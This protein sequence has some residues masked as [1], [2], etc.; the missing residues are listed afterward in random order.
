MHLV[1][2]KDL[3]ILRR[4]ITDRIAAVLSG[5]K[6]LLGHQ[7]PLELPAYLRMMVHLLARWVT[8][9][10]YKRI[11]KACF[12]YFQEALFEQDFD[13]NVLITGSYLVA[14]SE[15]TADFL[16]ESTWD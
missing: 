3:R 10:H 6:G 16:Q 8:K 7:R 9:H 12:S 11:E 4:V 1:L 13:R 2:I 15:S 5:T 14:K